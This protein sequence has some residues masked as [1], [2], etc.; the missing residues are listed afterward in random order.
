MYYTSWWRIWACSSW[1][2]LEGIGRSWMT[3]CA[4]SI[5]PWRSLTSCSYCSYCTTA[6]W[7]KKWLKLSEGHVN[8][9]VQVKRNECHKTLKHSVYLFS[10]L[11]A[12]GPLAMPFYW[13]PALHIVSECRIDNNMTLLCCSNSAS[14]CTCRMLHCW[15]A[16]C[17]NWLASCCRRSAVRQMA[18]LGI[19]SSGTCR[20]LWHSCTACTC[21]LKLS[22]SANRRCKNRESLRCVKLLTRYN[23]QSKCPRCFMTNY[24]PYHGLF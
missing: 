9:S 4:S 2:L 7:I 14:Y 17:C 5:S 10:L 23:V 1:M 8:P 15:M 3:R 21:C 24:H 13:H 18:R 20:A 12:C 22:I 6:S 19:T 16:T 11:M